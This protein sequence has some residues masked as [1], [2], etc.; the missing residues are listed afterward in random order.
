MQNDLGIPDIFFVVVPIIAGTLFCGGA[1]LFRRHG[2]EMR[3]HGVGTR[4]TVL[5]KFKKGSGLENGYAL[6]AYTDN[7][8]RQIQAEV[9]VHS[10]TWHGLKEGGQT[11][12]CYV[13]GKPEAISQGPM[14]GRKLI[15]FIMLFFA[16]VGGAMAL[17]G[18]SQL[19]LM[20]TKVAVK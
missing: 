20:L 12:I 6:L 16:F 18:L 14:F 5:K 10:R 4:A 13:P 17:L 11:D 7:T 8:G 9:W 1:L 2:R 19:V 15:G 3:E